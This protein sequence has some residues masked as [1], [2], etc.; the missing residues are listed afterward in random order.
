M[1]AID[2]DLVS[3][4]DD[5]SITCT[6]LKDGDKKW[7]L[8]VVLSDG[9]RLKKVIEPDDPSMDEDNDDNYDV[10]C[11]CDFVDINFWREHDLN[12]KIKFSIYAVEVG[13]S[14]DGGSSYTNTNVIPVCGFVEFKNE[15]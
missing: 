11:F 8:E 10:W 13:D 2:F 15:N 14:E 7:E 5:V 12:E 1:L 6:R 4:A 3:S 9:Q